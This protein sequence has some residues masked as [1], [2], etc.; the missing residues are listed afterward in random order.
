MGPFMFHYS[1]SHDNF[2]H[3]ITYHH[4]PE[5]QTEILDAHDVLSY[6]LNPAVCCQN[7]NDHLTS[8]TVHYELFS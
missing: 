7:F 2:Q 4:Q 6:L 5:R 3:L 8:F 1:I